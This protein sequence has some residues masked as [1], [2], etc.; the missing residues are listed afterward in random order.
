[1]TLQR[2]LSKSERT[3]S[4]TCTWLKSKKL[5]AKTLPIDFRDMDGRQTPIDL[6]RIVLGEPQQRVKRHTKSELEKITGDWRS[7]HFPSGLGDVSASSATAVKQ[8]DDLLDRKTGHLFLDMLR[9]PS[10]AI[11]FYRPYHLEPLDRWGIYI[12]VNRV[13]AYAQRVRFSIPFFP[14]VSKEV[15]MHLVLFEIFHHEF[16]HHLVESAA[17]TIE[18]MADAL[19]A[20]VPCY[21]DYRQ[22]VH[23]G[24]F[25]WHRHQPLEEALANAYAYNSFSFISRVRAGYRN[26]LVRSYQNNIAAHWR[27]EGPGYRDAANYIDGEQVP[28]NGD[29]L[30]MLLGRMPHP[31]LLQIAQ[32]VM[33]NGFSAFIRKPEIPTHFVGSLAEIE[34]LYALVPAPNETYCE[35]F[36]PLDTSRV[37]VLLKYRDQQRKDAKKIREHSN[38]GS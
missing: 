6:A 20:T 32:A 34:A 36:W 12:F 11:A 15:F 30:A 25:T 27:K 35:L 26:A 28:A 1:V 7:R 38:A 16:Y 37:D 2:P 3:L 17:T 24:K 10:N 14:N 21:L 23:H 31:G 33:P 19:G 4:D 13:L 29:L 9:L 18:I 5:T 8:L 22:A